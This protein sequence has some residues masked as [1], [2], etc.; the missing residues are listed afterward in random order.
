MGGGLVT[1]RPWWKDH[2]WGPL[3]RRKLLALP[4]AVRP[5]TARLKVGRHVAIPAHLTDLRGAFGDFRL[6][7]NHGDYFL[8]EL[9]A[10]ARI[11]ECRYHPYWQKFYPNSWKAT[12]RYFRRGKR[13]A[14]REAGARP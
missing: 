11:P 4:E 6:A 1:R 8:R 2:L 5:H 9:V 3:S 13:L 7:D 14:R 10:V 12:K